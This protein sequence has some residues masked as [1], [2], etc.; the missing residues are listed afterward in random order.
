MTGDDRVQQIALGSQRNAENRH[1]NTIFIRPRNFCIPSVI[2]R[3]SW[4][5]KI[6][7]TFSY[8]RSSRALGF[9]RGHGRCRLQHSALSLVN[10]NHRSR[11]NNRLSVSVCGKTRL[12]NEF[13]SSKSNNCFT[14]Q[15]CEFARIVLITCELCSSDHRLCSFILGSS[16][17]SLTLC[18]DVT[19][20]LCVCTLL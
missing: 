19:G 14:Y 5:E 15:F 18:R 2:E 12:E 8:R 1:K 11:A 17:S 20:D 4:S 13:T 7:K 10:S 16:R 9:W 6:R 3:Q